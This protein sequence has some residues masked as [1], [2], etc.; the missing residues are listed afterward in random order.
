MAALRLER[1]AVARLLP[2]RAFSLR[3]PWGAGYAMVLALSTATVSFTVYGP[4]LLARLFGVGPFAAGLLVASESV[5]WTLAALAVART[6]PEREPAL[7]RAGVALV[8]TGVAALAVTAPVGPPAAL[9]VGAALQGTGFGT[10]W[11]FVLRRIV[12]AGPD[13]VR[14][15]AF[16]VFAAF[17]PLAAAG[18]VAG[19]RM[20]RASAHSPRRGGSP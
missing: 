2:P 9:L 5:A 4:L 8:M 7:I 10:C 19:F 6:P 3:V 14:R 20:V 11:A 18:V 15:I 16:W 12:A 17:L 13:V 1:G